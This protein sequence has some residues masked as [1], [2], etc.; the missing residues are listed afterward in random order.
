[1][2]VMEKDFR[3]FHVKVQ[4]MQLKK[5]SFGAHGPEQSILIVHCVLHCMDGKIKLALT[6]LIIASH[7]YKS[8]KGELQQA[9]CEA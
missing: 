2:L 7:Y 9:V 1:M 6:L 5:L 8:G 4:C 3:P